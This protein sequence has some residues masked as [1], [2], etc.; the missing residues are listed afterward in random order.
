M[1]ETMTPGYTQGFGATSTS[2]YAALVES[3]NAFAQVAMSDTADDSAIAQ[4]RDQAK[5]FNGAWDDPPTYYNLNDHDLGDFIGD[6]ADNGAIETALRSAAQ[7]VLTALQNAVIAT[8]PGGPGNSGLSTYLPAPGDLSPFGAPYQAYTYSDFDLYNSPSGP[9]PWF[10]FVIGLGTLASQG[11]TAG[12]STGLQF[13]ARAKADP[14]H[15]LAGS[16]TAGT[17][18][19]A[20]G[21]QANWFQFQT[22]APGGPA[23]DVTITFPNAQGSL[24]LSLYDNNGN[25]LQTSTMASGVEQVNLGGLPAGTYYIEV[26]GS[27][28][29]PGY[30]L[31]IDSPP[32]SQPEQDWTGANYSLPKAV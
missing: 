8:N 2:E 17:Y 4:A 16:W 29:N 28:G 3:L 32:V 1:V 19:L 22:L 15:A 21:S 24:T 12:A 26:S 6:L 30:T 7:N 11:V 25:P 20:P 13:S 18:E 10:Q 14:L 31:T 5:V 27:H 9:T 23:N